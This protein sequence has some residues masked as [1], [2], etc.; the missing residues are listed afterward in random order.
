MIG[1]G[2]AAAIELGQ[3][4]I[5]VLRKQRFGASSALALAAR[6]EKRAVIAV[7][8][9]DA[10]RKRRA[11]GH[12]GHEPR[13]GIRGLGRGGVR[14]VHAVVDQTGK[15]GF[16]VAVHVTLEV[17]LVHA[18][19]A[20]QQDVLD[21]SFVLMIAGQCSQRQRGERGPNGGHDREGGVRQGCVAGLHVGSRVE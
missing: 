17:E 13:E 14:V 20:D 19:H 15:C 8:I 5:Q 12:E 10:V 16:R 11:A 7:V 6:R 4:V 2:G 9:E 1:A 3:V 21:T 18:V